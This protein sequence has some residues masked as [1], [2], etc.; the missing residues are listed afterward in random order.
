MK[1][2]R[3]AVLALA[4]GAASMSAQAAVISV[5]VPNGGFESS[6][7]GNWTTAPDAFRSNDAAHTGSWGIKFTDNGGTVSQTV[8]VFQVG[9]IYTFSYSLK[10][11]GTSESGGKGKVDFLIGDDT[12]QTW[13]SSSGW[14]QFTY[15]W[16]AN[17][18][19]ALIKFTG[20]KG[21]SDYY[22]DDVSVVLK[23]APQS[24]NV[25][26]PATLPLM[27]LGLL[28]LGLARRARR[29]A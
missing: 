21:R 24:G 11:G 13:T 14:T 26:L 9:G 8:G 29:A 7:S 22:L 17:A 19:N 18:E 2:I 25:P 20:Q 6:L 16:T 3:M 23:T 10:G 5:S 27:G 28:G 1:A 15:D 12:K 4:L